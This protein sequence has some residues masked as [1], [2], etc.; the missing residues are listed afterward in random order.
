MIIVSIFSCR[1]PRAFKTCGP[2]FPLI[3]S[4]IPTSY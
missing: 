4:T 3:S 1:Q 2:A